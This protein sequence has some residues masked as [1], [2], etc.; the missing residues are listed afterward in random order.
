MESQIIVVF[1][2]I[3][4]LISAARAPA[5]TSIAAYGLIKTVG[6]NTGKLN[7]G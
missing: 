4:R 1:C 6:V 5:I 3:C 7:G 2:T